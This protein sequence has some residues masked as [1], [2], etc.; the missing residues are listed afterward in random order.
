MFEKSQAAF[1]SG[2]KGQGHELL[3]KTKELRKNAKAKD[4]E[5]ARAIWEHRNHES[6]L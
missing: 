3:N 6:E 1:D 4:K 5:A 2:D